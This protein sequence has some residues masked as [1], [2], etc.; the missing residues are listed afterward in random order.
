MEE[1]KIWSI[2][3]SSGRVTALDSAAQ[4]E[5]EGLLEDILASNPD[6]LADGL[7]LI[8][9]QT[10]T[11]GGPLDLLGVDPDGRLSVFELKRGTLRREA[12]AQVIDYSS[13]L[14]DMD[15]ES[16]YRHIAEQSGNLGIPKIDDFEEWHRE[17]YADDASL[18]PLRMVLVG[19]G[20]DEPTERMVNYLVRS[21]VDMS[22]L[23]FH[24]FEQDG[25]TLFARHMEVDGS[26]IPVGPRHRVPR[27]QQFQ[28][29]I[30][31]VDI[32]RLVDDVTHVFRRQTVSFST[33]HSKNKRN[34][35]L[36][37]SWYKP[38]DGSWSPKGEA[39]TF[40]VEVVHDDIMLGFCAVAVAL[41]TPNEFERFK[42]EGIKLERAPKETYMQIGEVDY[43]YKVSVSSLEEWNDIGPQ[44]ATLVEKVCKEYT[45]A[46]QR[47]LSEGDAQTTGLAARR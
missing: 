47:A 31:S 33:T 44:L 32:G 45:S 14:E 1:L 25:K 17:N 21:G 3:N 29:S 20:V 9:R 35:C 30:Q 38:A 23:T 13:Y 11:T 40:F 18:T 8:G 22:L 19:L 5:S 26:N 37:Y 39:A 42:T 16:L 27:S 4:T 46:K 41:A 7:K 2:D 24:C 34:F 10:R 28:E 6:M 15:T 36:D 43:A 12:V